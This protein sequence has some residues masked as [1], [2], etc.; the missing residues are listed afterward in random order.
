MVIYSEI[1]PQMLDGFSIQSNADLI[2]YQVQFRSSSAIFK[3]YNYVPFSLILWL[4][5]LETQHSSTV[6]FEMNKLRY[7]N[8]LTFERD[9]KIDD[10][11]LS[12][13]TIKMSSKQRATCR[14]N[15]STLL[16][17][18]RDYGLQ[19]LYKETVARFGYIRVNVKIK[20]K[21]SILK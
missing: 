20:L 7:T 2:A 9:S 8:C 3:E 17:K 18:R 13:D 6:Y 21:R 12:E 4:G 14:C 16:R 15:I 11:W 5:D 19:E 10:S 1:I